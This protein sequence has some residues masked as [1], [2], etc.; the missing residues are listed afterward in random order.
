MV[1]QTG[2]FSRG[3][4]HNRFLKQEVEAGHLGV[5]TRMRY[6]NCHQGALAGWFDTQWRW[7]ADKNEAGGGG[8][9]DL[10]AHALDIVLWVL[11]EKCGPA[12]KFAAT[13]GNAT[14]R[15]GD[16]S[17]IDEW[18]AG[19]VT[20]ESG[21]VAILEAGWVDPKYSAP[22]EVH[23]TQGQILVHSGKVFYFSQHV[24]G[25]D[26]GEWT[27]LPEALPHAFELFWNKLEGGDAP[28]ISV[29]EAAEES[30]VMH[31]LYRAAG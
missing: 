1:F 13:L 21:A 25:A 29:R 20:F 27:Q 24:E 5:I 11:G 15:Y 22:I 19:M 12:V 3:T 10:G 31:E 28:L 14:G 7:I 16:L 4:A 6:T 8:F 23:G 2:F 17:Q 9:A 30:R 18:G 26:G